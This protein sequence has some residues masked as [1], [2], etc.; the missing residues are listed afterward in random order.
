M[1]HSEYTERLRAIVDGAID[2]HIDCGDANEIIVKE[3]TALFQQVIAE[4]MPVENPRSGHYNKCDFCYEV[5]LQGEACTCERSAG[6]AD[7]LDQATTNLTKI[8]KG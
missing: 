7:C 8:L 2:N 5:G 4:C 1:T 3:V 6:Y